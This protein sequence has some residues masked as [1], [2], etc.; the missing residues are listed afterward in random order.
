[1]RRFLRAASIAILLMLSWLGRYPAGAAGSNRVVLVTID[2]LAAYYLQDPRAELPTLHRLVAEGAVADGLRVSNPSTTWANHTTLVTGV[3]PD[4]HSVLFNGLLVREGPGQPL[5]IEADR[6]QAEL[7]AVPTVYDLLH[8][9]GYRTAAINWPCTRG[10]TTLDDNFPDV[11][12][13]ISHTTPRLRAEL[14]RDGILDRSGDAG[15][16]TQTPAAADVIWTSAALHLLRVRPPNLLLLH[17]LATDA[18]QHRHGPQSPAAYAALAAADAQLA[19]LLRALA[20]PEARERTTLIVTSDHGFARPTKLLRPN[21]VLRKAGLLRPGPHR[22]AQSI[23]AGGTAFVYLTHPTTAR[24]DRAKIMELLRGLEGVAEILGPQQFAALHL[25]NPAKNLR[26]ADLLLV[27]KEDYTFADEYLEDEVV[28]PIPMALGSHGYLSRD[29]RMNGVLVAW[30]RG[31]KPG[32]RLGWV[33]NIDVAPTIAAF[34]GE[35]LP[36]CEGTVIAP[37]ASGLEPAR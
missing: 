28:T 15:F 11:P 13:R 35:S 2:G 34:L 19:R 18:A 1:M 7:V 30:G 32:T 29:P 21:V 12:G 5:R 33:D 4:K 37:I 36:G 8:R 24:E 14:V 22:R 27:A 31:V 25:P 23:S 9:A 17:L 26:M 16:M 6:D 20:A 10:A 3:H